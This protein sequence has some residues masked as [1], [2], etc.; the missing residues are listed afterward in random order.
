MGAKR[1]PTTHRDLLTIALRLTSFAKFISPPA[2]PEAP[3][4]LAGHVR[5]CGRSGWVTAG[6]TR[7]RIGEERP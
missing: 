6:S 1:V 3:G 4:N 7:H 5:I 2:L